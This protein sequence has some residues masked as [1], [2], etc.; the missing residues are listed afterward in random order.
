MNPSP[1]FVAVLLVVASLPLTGYRHL[2]FADPL[3]NVLLIITDE[4]NFRTLG[5]YRQEMAREQAEMWG[6]R[7]C[8][9][10]SPY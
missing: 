8:R 4:H 7:R 1:S 2:A 3:P 9:S 10:N 5:C 6:A